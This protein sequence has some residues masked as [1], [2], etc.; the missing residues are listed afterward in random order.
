MLSDYPA[1]PVLAVTDLDRAR[2][3]YEDTLGVSGGTE[4]PGG[5]MYRAGGVQFLVYT[6]AFAGTNRATA[7]S[8]QLPPESFDREVEHLRRRGLEFD[9]FALDG[10]SWQ[11]GVA[12]GDG[13][14]AVWFADPDGNI[15]N[16]ETGA[17]APE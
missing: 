17:G 3:F 13:M 4:V 11:D 12:V 2:R 5:V 7:L 9:T 15:L 6:S 1:M 16:A 10:V 14:K 8:F